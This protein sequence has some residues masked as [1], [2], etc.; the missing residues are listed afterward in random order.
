MNKIS[1]S[2]LLLL[3]TSCASISQ[4]LL[5]SGDI[6]T[7]ELI[8]QRQYAVGAHR[9]IG[10]TLAFA[11]DTLEKTHPDLVL[12]IFIPSKLLGPNKSERCDH[13]LRLNVSSDLMS[14]PTER[15][16]YFEGS[17]G[18]RSK[19]IQCEFIEVG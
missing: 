8:H 6:L 1:I 9:Y 11:I 15:Q 3:L 10:S 16:H 4:E 14:V 17:P 19:P 12:D 2:L 13:L 18:D 5:A 7:I